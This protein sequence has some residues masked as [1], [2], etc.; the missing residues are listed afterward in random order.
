[1]TMPFLR[2]TILA[3]T[4]SIL[5]P[6]AATAGWRVARVAGSATIVM[7]NRSSD[8]SANAFVP[9]EAIVQTGPSGRVMLR[10]GA[11]TIVMGPRSSLSVKTGF[12]SSTTTVLQ[13]A[14]VAEFEVEHRSAPYFHV[15]TPMLA[16]IVKGTHFTVA[17][18]PR[19]ARLSV[20][21]GL[22]GVSDL[23]SG[24]TA[25]IARGESA[26]ATG[27]GLAVVGTEARKSLVKGEPRSPMVQAL[28]PALLNA[29][30]SGA[31]EATRSGQAATGETG[32]SAGG[33]APVGSPSASG[34]SPASRGASGSTGGGDGAGNEAG[35]LGGAVGG[36]GGAVGGAVGGVGGAVGGT[37]GSV[38]GAVTGV[39][40]AVGGTVGGAMGGVG[41]AV[42]GVS[43]AVG[44]AVGGLGGL[45]GLG[46]R[47]K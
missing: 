16:A 29:A 40:G 23:R 30:L 11:S 17:V 41:G 2:T 37:V 25:D 15:E 20:A 42:S 12:L 4:L 47:R 39:G 32:D 38:G 7:G 13:R 44:G 18:G 34:S 22:V 21:R 8:L 26:T 43:G 6:S 35:G 31:G 3:A 10:E 19:D 46:G 27:R 5:L 45:G 14:G 28:S 33:G 36:L 9:D 1:M 24:D